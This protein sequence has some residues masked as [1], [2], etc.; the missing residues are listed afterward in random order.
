MLL[1][2]LLAFGVVIYFLF[3][4]VLSFLIAKFQKHVHPQ[5]KSGY[6]K[7]L[8]FLLRGKR[9][10]GVI[11]GIVA[12]LFFSFILLG[13]RMPR[14]IFFPS[15]DPNNLQAY[16]TMPEG[17]HIDVTND[18]CKQVEEKIYNVIGRNNPDVES[19]VSNVA[20]NA[21][22]DMFER[23]TQDKLA[24]V[25][26]SFV[27]FKY[28]TGISTREYLVKLRGE[29]TGIAGAEIRIDEEM[30]G[31]PTGKPINMEISGD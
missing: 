27:E 3:K 9:P 18:I 26:I 31:P 25:A 24:R 8:A 30:M 15:G 13:I 16:I 21:G 7:T 20:A 5:M 19:V 11:A 29:L 23:F 14:V 6:R 4:F 1:A 2:N 22:S 28:R 17:T 10:Y 12:L